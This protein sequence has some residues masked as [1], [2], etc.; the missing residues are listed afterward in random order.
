MRSL[1]VLFPRSFAPFHWMK[2]I[3]RKLTPIIIA[4]VTPALLATPTLVN[5]SG[6][7]VCHVNTCLKPEMQYVD[8]YGRSDVG[9]ININPDDASVANQRARAPMYGTRLTPSHLTIN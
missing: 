6:N 5:I 7:L 8:L 1:I 3:G 4:V 2:I 9:R